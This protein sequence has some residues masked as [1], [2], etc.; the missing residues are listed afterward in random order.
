MNIPKIEF[1]VAKLDEIFPLMHHFLNPRNKD[2]DWSSAIYQSY[3]LLKG[4]LRNIKKLDKRKE[5]EWQFFNEVYEKEKIELKKQSEIF[6]M[7]WDKINSDVM[8]ALSD[9]VEQKWSSKDKKIVARVSLNPICPRDIK[10]RTF[11]VFYMQSL[12]YMK[13]VAIHETLHFIY[14]DK[15]KSVFPK[16]EAKE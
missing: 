4:K 2:W 5:I 16:A 9:V 1:M 15:W 3:P 12:E 6:Q 13:S 7:A 11:D 10:E 14:F 8:H